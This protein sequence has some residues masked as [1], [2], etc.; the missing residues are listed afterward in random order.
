MC[1]EANTGERMHMASMTM[2]INNNLQ[3]ENLLSDAEIPDSIVNQMTIRNLNISNL[4]PSNKITT[5]V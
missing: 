2:R 5:K 3:C 1:L 4:R